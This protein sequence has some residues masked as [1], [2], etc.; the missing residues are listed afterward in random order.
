MSMGSRELH[1]SID[2]SWPAATIGGEQRVVE[3]NL[4]VTQVDEDEWHLEVRAGPQGRGGSSHPTEHVQMP[5]R[6]AP[7]ALLV[8]ALSGE[9]VGAVDLR[10]SSP[11]DST[12]RTA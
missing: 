3:G 10:S 1:L 12:S 11:E 7:A 5:L 4:T 9:R 6:A 8:R 2:L